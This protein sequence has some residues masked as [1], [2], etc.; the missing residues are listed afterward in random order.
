MVITLVFALCGSH[1][2][3]AAALEA[4]LTTGFSCW[5]SDQQQPNN[6]VTHAHFSS[7]SYFWGK[8]NVCNQIAVPRVSGCSFCIEAQATAHLSSYFYLPKDTWFLLPISTELAKSLQKNLPKITNSH[9]AL[10]KW[11]VSLMS[12]RSRVLETF[13]PNLLFASLIW[14]K[15]V[16][17]YLWIPGSFIRSLKCYL[18][19]KDEAGKL[20]LFC[21]LLWCHLPSP[22]SRFD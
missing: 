1:P 14:D 2:P 13:E 12:W 10:I 19:W 4:N 15:Y 6:R 7:R 16:W 20:W 21:L 22:S 9:D 18:E 5:R 3:S 11:L 17:S 8:D